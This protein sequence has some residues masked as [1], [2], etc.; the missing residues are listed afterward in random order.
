MA[1]FGLCRGTLNRG[2]KGSFSR[3]FVTL[4]PCVA[5]AQLEACRAILRGR[6]GMQRNSCVRPC[7]AAQPD[8]GPAREREG[9]E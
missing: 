5:R 3:L 1:S 7:A 9:R 6:C 2:T 4:E 8:S